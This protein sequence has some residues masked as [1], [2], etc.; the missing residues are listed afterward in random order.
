MPVI[1]EAL[2]TIR[3]GLDQQLLPGHPS[4]IKATD[5]NNEHCTHHL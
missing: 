2:G 3:E 1:T 4:A 5:H